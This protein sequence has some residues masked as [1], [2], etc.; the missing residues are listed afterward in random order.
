MLLLLALGGAAAMA[1][2]AHAQDGFAELDALADGS[3]QPDRGVALARQQIGDGDLIGAVATL[4]R[5]LMD[6]PGAD[7]AVL[8]HASLLCRLDD[9]Q[10]GRAEIAALDA[11]VQVDEALWGE[12]TGACGPV[13]RPGGF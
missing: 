9:K 11:S 12:V 7:K 8:L 13:A 3:T 4:E 6:N 2:P 5:V 10:G 1:S